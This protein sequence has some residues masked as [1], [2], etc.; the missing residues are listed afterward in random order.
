MVFQ[1]FFT[2]IGTV[3]AAE[4]LYGFTCPL[5]TVRAHGQTVITTIQSFST[6]FAVWGCILLDARFRPIMHE[7]LAQL[8][9]ISF[10]FVVLLQA[11]Q[12]VIFPTLAEHRI[13][14]PSPPWLI[15]WNDFAVGLPQFLLVWEMVLVAITFIWAFHFNRY[16][17][18][19]LRDHEDIVSGPGKAFLD[20]LDLTDI[21]QT[22]A[23]AFFGIR[24]T[25]YPHQRPIDDEAVVAAFTDNDRT[26]RNEYEA[27]SANDRAD[28]AE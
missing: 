1:L 20:I 26:A 13:F 28:L 25:A 5:S 8:K 12:E 2:R 17:T 18:L 19:M 7:H 6:G 23:Y 14:K 21:W 24:S 10:K 4:F 11:V 15:S 9:L 16:R 27:K 22:V 3:L